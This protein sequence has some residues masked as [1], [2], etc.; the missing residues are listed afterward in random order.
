[1]YRALVRAAVVSVALLA[2][3]CPAGKSKKARDPIPPDEDGSRLWLRY[4]QV[5]RADRLAEYRAALT[6]VVRAG[7]SAPL[8]AAQS[9]LVS[10]LGGLLGAAVPVADQPTGNGAVVLGTPASS[11]I[12]RELALRRLALGRRLTA[13]GGEGYVVQVADVGGRS[14]VVV[15]ANTDVGVLRGSFAL[16]RHLQ[17]HRAVAGLTLTAAPKIQRR[18]L[19]HWDNLDGTVER[20]YAGRSLWNW[21]TLPGVVSPRIRDYARANASIGI[22]GTVLNNVNS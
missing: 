11:A 16:L 2:T 3:G 7:S 6:H 10:G 22:N 13:V 1:M 15:A 17:T 8:Q 4:Q 21:S 14:A 12:V 20:G 19:N 18:L 5:P 9:E